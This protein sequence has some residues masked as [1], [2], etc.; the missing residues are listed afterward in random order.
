MPDGNK[1]QPLSFLS[2]ESQENPSVDADLTD[3][4]DYLGVEREYLR[5][6]FSATTASVVFAEQKHPTGIWLHDE[7]HT[8]VCANRPFLDQ[9]GNCIKKRCYRKLMGKENIC[10]CCQSLGAFRSHTPRQCNPCDR[11]KPGFDINT[12]H[13]PITNTY[14]DRFILKSIFHLADSAAINADPHIEE[15]EEYSCQEILISCSA[16][17]KIKDKKDNWVLAD[18]NILERHRGRIS[19]GICPEC[20]TLLYPYLFDLPDSTDKKSRPE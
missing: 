1:K 13:V 17:H 16:C 4:L 5:K 11:N 7:Q 18:V 20:I 15:Q 2:S 14:G 10:G 6:T 19:H 9:Y 8:I 3:M 12:F